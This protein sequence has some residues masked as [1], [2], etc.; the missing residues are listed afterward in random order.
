[1]N[2]LQLEARD[3]KGVEDAVAYI[4]RLRQAK[5][6]SKLRSGARWW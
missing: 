1:V 6:K 2:A 5:D 3:M 4:A